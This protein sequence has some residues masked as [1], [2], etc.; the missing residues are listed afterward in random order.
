ML[1]NYSRAIPIGTVIGR[2]GTINDEPKYY[3]CTRQTYLGAR[4]SYIAC[5]TVFETGCDFA[6]CQADRALQVVMDRV[7]G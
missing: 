4:D 7:K 5:D 6:S 2:P 3:T 1:E